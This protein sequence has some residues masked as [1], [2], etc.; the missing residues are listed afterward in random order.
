MHCTI[1]QAPKQ[2]KSVRVHLQLTDHFIKRLPSACLGR[3]PLIWRHFSVIVVSRLFCPPRGG[4]RNSAWV[5]GWGIVVDL[6]LVTPGLDNEHLVFK[7]LNNV[8]SNWNSFETWE[9][10]RIFLSTLPGQLLA[11]LAAWRFGLESL[12]AG[13]QIVWFGLV[14][15]GTVDRTGPDREVGVV[16]PLHVGPLSSMSVNS[17]LS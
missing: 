1:V 15:F 2:P 9:K 16:C 3:F 17:S 14:W 5:C 7:A 12:L 11:G 6:L 8:Q 4:R 10:S 13:S